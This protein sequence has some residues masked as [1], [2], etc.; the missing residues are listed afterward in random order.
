M[1]AQRL[2]Q[3]IGVRILPL[4]TGPPSRVK[5]AAM[6]A[7]TSS[8]GQSTI[9]HAPVIDAANKRR[10]PVDFCRIRRFSV[11]RHRVVSVSRGL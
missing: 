7:A 6:S 5:T 2:A 10:T 11:A 9:T 4:I 1:D 3:L 8:V